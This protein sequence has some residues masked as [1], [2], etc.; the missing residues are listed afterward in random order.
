[1]K[2]L[3][4][5]SFCLG[6][7]LSHVQNGIL[8]HQTAYTRKILKRFHM[9]AS[10]PLSSPMVV[11]SLD[12]TKD[13]FRPCEEGE[14]C[15]PQDFPYLAAIGALMFLAI[16]TRPDIAFAVSLLAKYSARPTKRQWNGV[17]HIFRYLR[18]TEDLG[19]FY[20]D[21]C[22]LIGYADAG[23]L[24]DP[25]VGI[26]QTGYVF[27]RQG[28]AISWKSTKQTIVTTSSNHSEI[29]ALHEASRECVW[30][31]SIDDFIRRSTR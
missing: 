20:N 14:E 21:D 30:L 12:I 31:R 22:V 16:C 6:L 4:T 19:L 18:G 28:A 17:K 7:Q 27:L 23:Y 25:H 29:L 11:R 10:H 3:G 24:S 15:L 9:D 1:M 26:S 8:L 5:T 13:P 2:D